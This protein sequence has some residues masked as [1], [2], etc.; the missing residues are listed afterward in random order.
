M[1]VGFIG[2][3]EVAS[4][5]SKGLLN[6]GL[7]VLTCVNGRSSKSQSLAKK[8]GVKLCLRN[9]DVAEDADILISSVTPDM[10]FHVAKELGKS[11]K[12]IYVDINNVSSQT[13]KNSLAM[14]KNQKVVDAAIIGSVHKE[15]HMVQIIAS[16]NSA[17]D[18]EKLNDFGLNIKVVGPEVGQASSIKML[19]SSYTK[20]VSTLLWETIFT[21]YKMG[22]D[23]EVLNIIAE[24]E[25]PNFEESAKSRL[26]SSAFHS[27]RRF[28]EMKEVQDFLSEIYEPTM[29][30]CSGN[31]FGLIYERLGKLNERPESYRD[32]FKSFDSDLQ[33]K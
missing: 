26:V 22:I 11:S 27:K 7:D 33:N 12:G 8:S 28:N 19:R 23:E 32:V 13:V 6:E 3:G 9:S 31:V 15:G 20:G 29:A 18:F 5:L 10:A 24:T 21:A 17:N 1:K 30:K 2:F 16:G 14:I 25:G 4:V